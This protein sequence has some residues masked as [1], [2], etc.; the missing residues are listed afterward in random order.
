MVKKMNPRKS[1]NEVKK[2][3]KEYWYF[4]SYMFQTSK[5]SGEGMT[6]I[7]YR[8]HPITDMEHIMGV[9]KF[10]MDRNNKEAKESPWTNVIIRNFI[11]LRVQGDDD[12]I[13]PREEETSSENDTEVPQGSQRRGSEED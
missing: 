2:K 9:A 13:E 12:A 4:V 7:C 1:E 10:I 11:L 5:G 6:T 3:V 8:S